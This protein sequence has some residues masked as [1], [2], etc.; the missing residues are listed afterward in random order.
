MIR[1][2]LQIILKLLQNEKFISMRQVPIYKGQNYILLEKF[3]TTV[4]IT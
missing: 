4:N 3:L 1:H 2:K